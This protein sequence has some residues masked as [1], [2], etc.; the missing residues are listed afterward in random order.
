[1]T[2]ILFM[3]NAP[4]NKTSKIKDLC[5]NLG[6]IVLFNSPHSPSMN[7]IEEVWRI[8]KMSLKSSPTMN[9]YQTLITYRDEVEITLKEA[10]R[11]LNL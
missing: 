3:D 4:V 11:N 9:W 7:P 8:L 1:M 10:L 2:P 6:V 5:S